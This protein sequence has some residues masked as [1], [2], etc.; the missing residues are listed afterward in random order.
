MV[1]RSEIGKLINQKLTGKEIRKQIK[2][3]P[4]NPDLSYFESLG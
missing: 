2:D 1:K 4:E 3:F